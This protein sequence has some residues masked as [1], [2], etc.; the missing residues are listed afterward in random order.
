MAFDINSLNGQWHH[1]IREFTGFDPYA[2]GRQGQNQPCP[3]CGGQNRFFYTNK[4]DNGTWGCRQCTP[5]G[6]D[7]IGLIAGITRA[8]RKT[9]FAKIA[10]KYDRADRPKYEKAEPAPK[11]TYE[12]TSGEWDGK[13]LINKPGIKYDFSH[14]WKWNNPDGSILGYVARLEFKKGGEYT[15]LCWQILPGFFD[16][17]QEAKHGWYQASINPKPLFGYPSGG[18]GSINPKYIVIVEG[19]KTCMAAKK[20]LGQ[21]YLVLACQGG[22]SNVKATDFK[23]LVEFAKEHQLP[24][25]AWGDSDEAGDKYAA[26][27]AKVTGATSIDRNKYLPDTPEGWDLADANE[28]DADIY[29]DVIS[30]TLEDP[31]RTLELIINDADAEDDSDSEPGSLPSINTLAG[32][33]LDELLRH[34]NPLGVYE[35]RYVFYPKNLKCVMFIPA[36]AMLQNATMLSIV[37]EKQLYE[38]FPKV[39]PE[40]EEVKGYNAAAAGRYFMKQCHARGTYDPD[41]MRGIG[42][43]KDRKRLVVNTGSKLVVDGESVAYD[44]FKSRYTYAQPGIGKIKLAPVANDADLALVRDVIYNFN[45]AKPYHAHLMLGALVQAPIAAALRWRAHVWLIGAQ[46]S[47]KSF[48]QASFIRALLGQLCINFGGETTAAGVRQALKH[49]PF[50]VSFDEAEVRSEADAKR[51]KDII[52]LARISSSDENTVVKGSATGDAMEFRCQSPFIMSSIKPY[53]REESDIARFAQL[54]LAQPGNSDADREAFIRVQL[55]CEEIDEDF[56]ARWVAFCISMLEQVETNMKIVRAALIKKNLSPRTIDQYGQLIACA[57]V[58]CPDINLN[59]FDETLE[60]AREHTADREPLSALNKL[61]GAD[62]RVPSKFGDKT[63]TIR[64]AVSLAGKGYL[65]DDALTPEDIEE[66]LAKYGLKVGGKCLYIASRSDEIEKILGFPEWN[67]LLKII[68][69]VEPG[70]NAMSFGSRDYKC[71]YVK[72]PFD[73]FASEIERECEDDLDNSLLF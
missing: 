41:C 28:E 69:G 25:V 29:K 56:S 60:E 64:H 50:A 8:D 21:D 51:M 5:D 47:G 73:I 57:M 54:E 40:T 39:D 16:N 33:S 22:S 36:S 27:V 44:D 48:F 24:I 31:E 1:L 7:G 49:N 71:R 62:I 61:L 53:L 37:G 9:V 4:H 65:I 70:R 6:S 17:G 63:M 58:V 13:T 35:G 72:I 30:L 23:P 43:W 12:P 42:I 32:L 66:R 68:D 11:F 38:F 34:V 45:W 19:E 18:L 2:A 10:K 46:G 67:K 26:E 55:L 3:I 52:S 15:K 20:L 59:D 14:V